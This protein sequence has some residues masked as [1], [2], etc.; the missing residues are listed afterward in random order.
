MLR[1]L[2]TAA[3]GMKAQQMQVD[4]I[5]NNI[6]NSNTTG[7]K[8]NRLSFQSLYYQTYRNQGA[9]LGSGIVD[10]TGL[11]VGSG[12]QVAGSAMMME[13]GQLELTGNS[14]DLA[15]QG[16]GFFAVDQPSGETY[17]TRDGS[18]RRDQNGQ[19]RTANG[20]TLNPPITL[21]PGV[22]A[23]NVSEAGVVSYITDTG[24]NQT[25]GT[26]QLTRF[27]NAMGLHA[28]GANLLSE[29]ASSG[30]PTI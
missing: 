24:D 18:F 16:E 14:F 3:S 9:E 15:I 11:Q 22:M 13:Q 8:K 7:F 2:L 6:S 17:Y 10:A 29:T 5:A 27:P 12:T 20:G 4:T 30:A 25:A 1:S 21:P 23:I 28:E 19:L 26:I